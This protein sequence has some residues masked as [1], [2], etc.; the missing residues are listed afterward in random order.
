MICFR[1][2]Q[3]D[4]CQNVL[5]VI[6]TCNL[7]WMSL[8]IDIFFHALQLKSQQIFREVV[9]DNRVLCFVKSSYQTATF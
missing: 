1:V 8:I 9:T 7:H 5:D 3:K 4:I 6:G 2:P